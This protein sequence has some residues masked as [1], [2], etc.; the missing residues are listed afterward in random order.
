MMAGN[1]IVI[2]GNYLLTTIGMN[3]PI[4]FIIFIVILLGLKLGLNTHSCV[5]ITQQCVKRKYISIGSTV[6][7]FFHLIGG[8]LGITLYGVIVDKK[9]KSIYHDFNPNVNNASI[10]DIS[11]LPN[12]TKY[13]IESIQFTYKVVPLVASVITLLCICFLKKI[14]VIGSRIHSKKNRKSIRKS[15]LK[16]NNASQH[17]SFIITKTNII[18]DNNVSSPDE[19]IPDNVSN[20]IEND[21]PPYLQAIHKD[22]I[23]NN[24][25][26][27]QKLDYNRNRKSQRIS[28]LFPQMNEVNYEEINRRKSQRMSH[29]VSHRISYILPQMNE[30]NCEEEDDNG[31]GDDDE[32]LDDDSDDDDEIEITLF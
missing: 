22:M 11:I 13:Y 27:S 15:C 3:T 10:K 31:N 16:E 5:L 25:I 8:N 18:N 28:Y 1:L 23:N 20:N 12:G 21:L 9:F 2:L 7:T 30:I 14:P 6:M 19:V 17:P 4:M 24:T 32:V 29:R 26:R